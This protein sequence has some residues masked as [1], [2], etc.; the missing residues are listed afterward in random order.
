MRREN[1]MCFQSLLAILCVAVSAGQSQTITTSERYYTPAEMRW[2]LQTAGF[3]TANIFGCHLGQFSR[4]HALA[5]D[6][7][8]MLVVAE[9]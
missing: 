4:E 3:A 5:H 9:K 2:L 8:E 7:F 6:D 1:R